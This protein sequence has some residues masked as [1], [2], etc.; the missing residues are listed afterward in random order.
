MT[1]LPS[2]LAP[3]HPVRHV[4]LTVIVL[5]ALLVGSTPAFAADTPSSACAPVFAEYDG[6]G[7][8]K[9]LAGFGTRSRVIQLAVGC[10]CLGLFILI[11]GMKKQ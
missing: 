2:Q 1:A 7:V 4:V 9:F 5:L 10:M 8:R 11:F 6:W 3:A